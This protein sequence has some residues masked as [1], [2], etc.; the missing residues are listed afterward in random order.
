LPG[1]GLKGDCEGGEEGRGYERI[2]ENGKGELIPVRPSLCCL[3][4]RGER[5]QE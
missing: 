3:G 2:R 4:L 5:G 1:G